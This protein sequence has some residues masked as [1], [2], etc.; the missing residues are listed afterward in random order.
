[1]TGRDDTCP[2]PEVQDAQAGIEIIPADHYKRRTAEEVLVVGGD[3]WAI[4]DASSQLTAAGRT[5]YRC[6]DSSETPFPCNALVPGRG[7]PL[8]HHPVDAVLIV[9]SRPIAEPTIAEMGAI[10]ALRD[11]LPVVVGGI[12]EASAFTPW[13][14]RVPTSGDILTTLDQTVGRRG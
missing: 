10:C 12:S 11:G 1:M 6:S 5:V 7:C 2:M 3:D 8:D 13:A 14:A 4:D 9:R